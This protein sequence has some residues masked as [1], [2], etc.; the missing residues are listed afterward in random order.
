MIEI[1]SSTVIP[2]FDTHIKV[3]AGPGAGKTTWLVNHINNVLS[4]SG[5]LAVSRKIACI[6]YT[7][8]AVD[9]LVRRLKEGVSQVEVTTIH[10][11]LY[12]HVLKPYVSFVSKE[13]EIDVSRIK[14]HDD[15]VLSGYQFLKDWKAR[16]GQARIRDDNAVSL[17]FKTLRWK[18]DSAGD[19]VI[20]TPYPIKADGYNI[21]GGSYFEYKKMCWAKGV[22]HH[23]DVLFLSFKLLEKFPFIVE[24]LRA[25]FPYFFIDEFQDINPIQLKILQKIFKKKLFAP[26][27]AIVLNQ[28]TASWVLYQ[29]N[30]L[31][32][33]LPA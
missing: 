28:S 3:S 25:K 17:A 11:F 18:F 7:N 4:K 12:R 10:S 21:K 22:I 24:V 9:T 23:D 6:T 29:S 14:G 33:K 19:L 32:L 1:T 16:T 31:L 13:Y 20:N 5:R 27:L 26:L 30:F 8:V 15:K 2:N